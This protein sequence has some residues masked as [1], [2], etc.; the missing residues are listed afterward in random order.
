MDGIS[1]GGPSIDSDGTIFVGVDKGGSDG[2]IIAV[3]PDGTEKWNSNVLGRIS[4]NV[5]IVANDRIYIGTKEGNNLL[6]LDRSTGGQIWSFDVPGEIILSN[7]AVD[8]N[9]NIYFGAWNKG[10]YSIDA[11]AQMRFGFECGRVWSSPVIG[12]D[13]TVYFGS[14]DDNFYALEM[15]AEGLANDVWPMFGKNLKHT[16]R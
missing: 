5:P 6:A 7:P 8:V 13:G 11:D 15:F 2:A 12:Q 14:Y 10:F 9:G 3:N 4:V 1:E 16:S